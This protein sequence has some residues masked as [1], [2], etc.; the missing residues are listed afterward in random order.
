M[1]ELRFIAESKLLFSVCVT[2]FQL[3][4]QRIYHM[5][6]YSFLVLMV[7]VHAFM[8]CLGNYAAE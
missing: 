4:S 7:N 6:I 8:I 5:L 1:N 2:V 3:N